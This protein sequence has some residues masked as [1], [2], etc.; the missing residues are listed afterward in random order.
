[1][2]FAGTAGSP[3]NAALLALHFTS[4]HQLST[5]FLIIGA[6]VVVVSPLLD[7]SFTVWALKKFEPANG[8]F[9]GSVSTVEVSSFFREFGMII[10][11]LLP[12]Q[13]S[14]NSTRKQSGDA[15]YAVSAPSSDSCV[16]SCSNDRL[17]WMTWIFIKTL[18]F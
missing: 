6:V 14:G 7:I 3:L 8:A 11:A 16:A 13:S 12:G 2:C 18:I 9:W 17:G 15:M 1:M 5:R 4:G 10:V